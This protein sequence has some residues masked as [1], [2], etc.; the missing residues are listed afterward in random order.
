MIVYDNT[1]E[2][3]QAYYDS[4]RSKVA[5]GSVDIDVTFKKKL[6]CNI[7]LVAFGIDQE[8]MLFDQDRT[9]WLNPPELR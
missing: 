7:H 1:C 2:G 6:P 9:I 3:S 4:S 5:E 8:T